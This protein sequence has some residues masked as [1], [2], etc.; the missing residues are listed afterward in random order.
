VCGSFDSEVY[1]V[2]ALVK[3]GDSDSAALT[4]ARQEELDAEF[5]LRIHLKQHRCRK[6]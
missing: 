2:K 5:E 1:R 6:A 3:T 4:S